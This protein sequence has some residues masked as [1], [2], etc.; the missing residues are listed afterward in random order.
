MRSKAQD[1]SHELAMDKQ[2]KQHILGLKQAERDAQND[3]YQFKKDMENISINRSKVENDH[4]QKMTQINQSH[5][6]NM[7]KIKGELDSKNNDF[8]LKMEK[9]K[10]EHENRKSERQQS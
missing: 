4:T 6:E 7:L 5:E 3:A 10:L 8:T 1:Q 9:L 2:A